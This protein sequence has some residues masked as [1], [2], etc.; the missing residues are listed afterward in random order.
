MSVCAG[1][2]GPKRKRTFHGTESLEAVVKGLVEQSGSVRRTLSACE[3]TPRKQHK[4]LV[5]FVSSKHEVFLECV[6]MF[7]S[8]AA[9]R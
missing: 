5:T 6:S 9:E 4:R 2:S 1:Q 7:L 8:G 3:R